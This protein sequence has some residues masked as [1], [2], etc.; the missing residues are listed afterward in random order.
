MEFASSWWFGARLARIRLPSHPYGIFTSR[1]YGIHVYLYIRETARICPCLRFG[2]GHDGS[3]SVAGAPK[4]SRLPDPRIRQI[5]GAATSSQ[6]TNP[7]DCQ[8]LGAAKSLELPNPPGCQILETAKSS[9]LPHPCVCQIL[10]NL[11]K[12]KFLLKRFWTEFRILV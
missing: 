5:L 8:I 10:E 4:S 7:R 9:Q 12:F 6:L 1:P 2:A 3:L 11:L